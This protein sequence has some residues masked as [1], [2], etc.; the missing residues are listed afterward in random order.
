M[1]RFDYIVLGA[2]LFFYKGKSSLIENS[3]VVIYL[4]ILYN[5]TLLFEL[6]RFAI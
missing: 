3:S 1:E 6:R 5:K 4:K 2:V